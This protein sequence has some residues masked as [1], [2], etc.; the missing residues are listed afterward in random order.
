MSKMGGRFLNFVS[1]W[2]RTGDMALDLYTCSDRSTV[3][4]TIYLVYLLINDAAVS[5]L[6]LKIAYDIICLL[7]RRPYAFIYS[8]HIL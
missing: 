1:S 3:A 8:L 6:L 7:T 4:I 5:S 2:Y